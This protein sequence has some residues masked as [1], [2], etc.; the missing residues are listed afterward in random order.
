MTTPAHLA[1]LAADVEARSSF[2]VKPM[3]LST[4]RRRG[5]ETPFLK[6]SDAIRY[7]LNDLKEWLY[8][9]RRRSTSDDGLD[10]DRLRRQ[11]RERR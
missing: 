3:T 1:S 9:Q 10:H 2:R 4:C 7:G 6:M 5:V 11:R 8:E